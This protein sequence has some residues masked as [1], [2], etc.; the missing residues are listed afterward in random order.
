M[1]MVVLVCIDGILPLG[2]DCLTK[3][4]E[5]VAGIDAGVISQNPVFLGIQDKLPGNTTSDRM[6]FLKQCF[7]AIE[8]WMNGFIEKTGITRKRFLKV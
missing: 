1:R 8:G 3:V 5:I 6:D 4:H 2:P 7:A